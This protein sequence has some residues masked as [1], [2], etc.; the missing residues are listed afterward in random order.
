[1]Y[2]AINPQKYPCRLH[3]VKEALK[4][5]FPN[6]V[7]LAIFTFTGEPTNLTA[8]REGAPNGP[9]LILTGTT[10]GDEISMP[11]TEFEPGPNS[12]GFKSDNHPKVALK[13]SHWFSTI[14]IWGLLSES[15]KW[16]EWFTCKGWKICALNGHTLSSNPK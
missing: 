15:L 7:V 5:F 16:S 9:S 11:Y 2:Q 12:V 8:I 6:D 13:L 3:W 14:F 4:D 1:M 10:Q